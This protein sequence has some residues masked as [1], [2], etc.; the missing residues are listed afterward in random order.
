MIFIQSGLLIVFAILF[1]QSGI[2][3][4]VNFKDNL[5][6]IV[7]VFSKTFLNSFSTILFYIITILEVA[8]GALCVVALLLLLVQGKIDLAVIALKLSA[9]TLI[10]LFGGQRIAKDYAGAS[11]IVVYIILNFLALFFFL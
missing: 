4:V 10:C 3:K 1:L 7:S 9:V 11:G 8:T 2:D 6:Y 5:S